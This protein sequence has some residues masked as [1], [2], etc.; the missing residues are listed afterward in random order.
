[1]K[2]Q[3]APIQQIGRSVATTVDN[4]DDAMSSSVED[5][6][7]SSEESRDERRVIPVT[8]QAMGVRCAVA[9]DFDEDGLLDIV[10]ASSDDNA[11]SWYKNL[12]SSDETGIPSFSVKKK[13]TWQSL[14]SRIVTVGYINSDSH[15]DVVGASYYDGSLR[16]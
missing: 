14:G 7:F 8:N 15:I 1:M 10:S 11:V 13:I 6:V 5:D 16:W 4:M 2:H 9:A 3:E 12:G